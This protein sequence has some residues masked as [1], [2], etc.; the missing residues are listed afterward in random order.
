MKVK[1]AFEIPRHLWV[2]GYN[3][4]AEGRHLSPIG[5]GHDKDKKNIWNKKTRLVRSG[6]E[7]NWVSLFFWL[8]NN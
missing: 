1:F 7:G 2:R 4:N 8:K 3:P 5:I 6:W